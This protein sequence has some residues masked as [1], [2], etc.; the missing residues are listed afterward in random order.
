[1]SL[2]TEALL[3]VAAET[4]R[5]P[6]ADKCTTE[7]AVVHGLHCLVVR[8]LAESSLVLSYVSGSKEVPVSLP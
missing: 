8:R 5:A 4:V 6:L 2:Q 3:M 7:A 1:M